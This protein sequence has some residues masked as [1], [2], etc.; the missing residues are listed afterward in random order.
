MVDGIICFGG[1]YV[2]SL[3]SASEGFP[4]RIL[5]ILA[6]NF[7]GLYYLSGIVLELGLAAAII[8]ST[9][10]YGTSSTELLVAVKQLAGPASGLN[11]VD[12]A[13]SVVNTLKVLQALEEVARLMQEMY[14]QS[15]GEAR[16]SLKNLS[17]MLTLSRAKSD[18]GFDP[19]Q[20][21]LTEKQAG[22]IALA[23]SE[24]DLNDNGSLDISE[25][26][27]LCSSLGWKLEEAE[28]KEAYM[29]LDT[30]ENGKV[31][32]K[33]FVDWWCLRCPLDKRISV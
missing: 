2:A 6:G 4:S 16:D 24:F 7:V 22:N 18:L 28:L 1:F 20:Y 11:I 25:I 15:T 12:K 9:F 31:D 26:G 13:S 30:D 32:F 14:G 19:G 33:E 23:F 29:T 27:N 5:F 3:A 8:Y 21:G 17:A 10:R